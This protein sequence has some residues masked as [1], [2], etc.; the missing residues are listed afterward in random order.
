MNIEANSKLNYKS[1][2]QRIS[3]LFHNTVEGKGIFFEVRIQQAS[4]NFTGGDGYFQASTGQ[5]VETH[6]DTIEYVNKAIEMN[7]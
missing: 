6:P 5:F 4:R 1:G 3:V 7:S 2:K